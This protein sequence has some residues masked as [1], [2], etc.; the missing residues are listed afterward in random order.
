V[1]LYSVVSAAETAALVNAIREIDNG[2]FVNVLRTEQ[3]N[4]RFYT[5]PKD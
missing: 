1:L 4:G 5:R 2:A 3:I